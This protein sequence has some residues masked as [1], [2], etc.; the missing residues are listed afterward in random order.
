MGHEEVLLVGEG[1]LWRVDPSGAILARQDPVQGVLAVL[2]GVPVLVEHGWSGGGEVSVVPG[3]GSVPGHVDA[4]V[5][6]DRSLLAST[7]STVEGRGLVVRTSSTD[8][9]VP[10][11]DG[12]T[13]CGDERTLLACAGPVAVWVDDSAHATGLERLGRGGVWEGFPV[14]MVD[15]RIVPLRRGPIGGPGASIQLDVLDLPDL[16]PPREADPDALPAPWIRDVRPGWEEATCDPSLSRLAH[17]GAGRLLCRAD[18]PGEPGGVVVH[19]VETGETVWGAQSLEGFLAGAGDPAPLWFRQA[20]VD[21]VLPLVDV[22]LLDDL[23]ERERRLVARARVDGRVERVLALR[24]HLGWSTVGLGFGGEEALPLSPRVTASVA[25]L[26]AWAG[27]AVEPLCAL[28]ERLRADRAMQAAWIR[29]GVHLLAPED[30]GVCLVPG[31]LRLAR[32]VELVVTGG[33]VGVADGAID[34]VAWLEG[35]SG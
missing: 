26:R 4:I 30:D 7:W 22:L 27:S 5:A 8:L 24:R 18:H 16:A 11:P 34:A 23:R 29:A 17:D 12:A 10:V 15:G 6:N 14:V 1:G 25:R 3:R 19:T 33:R 32:G 35:L 31:R 20:H 21:P 13:L 28:L 2:D 9:R